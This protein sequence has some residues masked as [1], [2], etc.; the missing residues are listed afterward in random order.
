MSQS[1]AGYR[2]KEILLEEIALASLEEMDLE[3]S[4]QQAYAMVNQHAE[5]LDRLKGALKAKILSEVLQTAISDINEEV[6]YTAGGME[7]VSSEEAYSTL[8]SMM[9]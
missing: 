1:A 2:L 5:V 4:T 6:G 3:A 9:K 8:M 7:A